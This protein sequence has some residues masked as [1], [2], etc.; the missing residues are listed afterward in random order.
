MCV[1]HNQFKE[2]RFLL[3]FQY[4]FHSVSSIKTL[5]I[6]IFIHLQSKVSPNLFSMNFN[7]NYNSV[8]QEGSTEGRIWFWERIMEQ[9]SETVNPNSNKLKFI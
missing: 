7:F 2:R 5:M 1:L 4:D 9:G 6:E 3:R 8:I